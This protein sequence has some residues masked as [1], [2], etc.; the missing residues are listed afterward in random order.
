MPG[1]FRGLPAASRLGVALTLVGLAI[2]LVVH[3]VGGALTRGPA[4]AAGHLSTLIGMVVAIAGVMWMGLR[5][6]SRS[7]AEERRA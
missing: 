5:A 6:T 7:A 4:A 1:L 2:D 3:A